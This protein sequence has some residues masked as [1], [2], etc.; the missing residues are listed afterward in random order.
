[1]ENNK[2]YIEN[3][4]YYYVNINGKELKYEKKEI[5]NNGKKTLEEKFND[6]NK[7]LVNNNKDNTLY[8][9]LIKKY[10]LTADYNKPTRL[11]NSVFTP[12]NK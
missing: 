6:G 8:D 12:K 5:D 2:K 1:M 10:S 3:N 7:T 4:T 11:M 9:Y